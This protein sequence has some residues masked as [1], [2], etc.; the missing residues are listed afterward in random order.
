MF[1]YE[2]N[3]IKF[4]Y[5]LCQVVPFPL[6]E[7]QSKWI[8]GA[9]SGKFPLPSS[10]EMMKDVENFYSSMEAAGIPKRYTHNLASYQVCF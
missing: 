4:L 9:L 6:F 8:A 2:N 10:E 7:F 1:Y 5:T 3:C